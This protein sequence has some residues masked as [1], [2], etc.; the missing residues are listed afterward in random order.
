MPIY[1]K[2]Y[3]LKDINNTDTLYTNEDYVRLFGN[4]TVDEIKNELIEN[5]LNFRTDLNHLHRLKNIAEFKERGVKINDD[6]DLDLVKQVMGDIK[7]YLRDEDIEF[8][9]KHGRC[10][11]QDILIPS[12]DSYIYY[13]NKYGEFVV[14]S[15]FDFVYESE[16]KYQTEI[17]V[18]PKLFYV[19]I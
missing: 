14:T 15:L 7:N 10:M 4:F 12:T 2:I 1:K 5:T 3:T 6:A 18:I 19:K 11:I 8:F 9:H 16:Y 13:Q 17:L